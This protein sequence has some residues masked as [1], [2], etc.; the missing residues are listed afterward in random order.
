MTREQVVDA[1]A[2]L[3]RAFAERAEAVARDAIAERGRFALGIPGGSVARAFLPSLATASIDWERTDL[4][5]VDERCVPADHPDSNFGLGKA[6]LLRRIEGSQPRVHRMEGDAADASGAATAYERD[7]EASLGHPPRFDLVLLGVG[8]DGHVASLFPGHPALSER[9]RRVLAL[10]D[11]PKPPPR[12][13]TLTLPAFEAARLICIAAFGAEKA[14][15]MREAI[16]KEDSSLPVA[17]A[18]RSGA[19]ALFLLDPEAAALIRR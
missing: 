4:F 14:A 19:H 13:L 7:L 16:E 1:V 17:Q 10:D 2:G 11:A 5:W 12:R 18:A 8:P 15:A 6:L 9:G 3:A